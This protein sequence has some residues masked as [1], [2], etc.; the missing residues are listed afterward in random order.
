MSAEQNQGKMRL[1]GIIRRLLP[2]KNSTKNAGTSSG[3]DIPEATSSQINNLVEISEDMAN[4]LPDI[5]LE[6][7][8]L[9]A[10]VSHLGDGTD[11]R[12]SVPA[13]LD[14]QFADS[15]DQASISVSVSEAPLTVPPGTQ[16]VELSS[17]DA[18]AQE[19]SSQTESD[20]AEL[21]D[22]AYDGLKSVDHGLLFHYEKVIS[23]YLKEKYRPSPNS[24]SSAM[25]ELAEINDIS[26]NDPLA[27]RDQMKQAMYACLDEIDREK[28]AKFGHGEDAIQ[29]T[30]SFLEVVRASAERKP[31]II[32]V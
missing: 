21:W 15:E 23:Y 11:I 1:E 20:V 29:T 19:K 6:G 16:S 12:T 14:E 32:I 26:Q 9:I 27:R 8:Q 2:R 18:L 30:R 5:P 10:N 31:H 25:V 13:K 22:T 17:L 3:N 7:R 28:E 4:I 24:S